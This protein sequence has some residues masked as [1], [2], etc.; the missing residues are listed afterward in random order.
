M[1]AE[2]A[3]P[4]TAT[5]PTGKSLSIL[6]DAAHDE[7]SQRHENRVRQKTNFSSRFNPIPPVQTSRKKY[8]AFVFSEISVPS[9]HPALDKGAFRDRHER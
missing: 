6:I 9:S 7:A 2:R 8:S 3:S 5:D 4:P 1:T